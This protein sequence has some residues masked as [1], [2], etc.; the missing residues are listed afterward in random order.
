MVPSLP[1]LTL[2]IVAPLASLEIRDN[3]GNESQ[4]WGSHPYGPMLHCPYNHAK[5]VDSG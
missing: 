1:T 4:F 2:R 5:P 3:A